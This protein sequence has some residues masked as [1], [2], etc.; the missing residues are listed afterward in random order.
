MK[1]GMKTLL[2]LSLLCA[3]LNPAL[4]AQEAQ[5]R[6]TQQDLDPKEFVDA[7]WNLIDA[8]DAG[9]AGS[10]WDGAS[11]VLKAS[12]QRDRF[13]AVMRQRT[14]ANGPLSSRRWRAITR[15]IQ[16][17][18]TPQMPAGEYLSVAFIGINKAGAI[19]HGTVSFRVEKDSR[20]KL[21]GYAL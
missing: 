1:V 19:V 10:I 13:I 5:P 20:W 3:S 18:A 8:I 12:Q 11:P 4:A 16:E 7:A 9:Q 15:T 21:A 6:Q 17:K 14:A 2:A